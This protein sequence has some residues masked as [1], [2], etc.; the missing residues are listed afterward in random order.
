MADLAAETTAL[1]QTIWGIETE[2][3]YQA[4]FGG[5]GE[6]DARIH[7]LADRLRQA[8]ADLQMLERRVAK[9]DTL[10]G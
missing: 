2:L 7:A 3:A 5:K 10:A 9:P 8:H 4:S 1:K 6:D